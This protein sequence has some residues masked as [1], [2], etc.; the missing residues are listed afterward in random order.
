MYAILL[1][2]P[3][4]TGKSTYVENHLSEFA[5]LSTDALIIKEAAR[6]GK[7]YVDIFSDYYPTAEDLF[8]QKIAYCKERKVGFVIDRTNLTEQSW[9]RILQQVDSSFTKVAIYFPAYS[10]EVL[11]GRIDKRESHKVPREVVC[12]QLNDYRLP[13]KTEGFDLV[14]SSSHFIDVLKV[15]DFRW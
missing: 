2:G 13:Q 10:P 11:M 4:G 8:K 14:V 12:K 6:Q 7:T 9:K 1:C 15:M 5:H 3:S